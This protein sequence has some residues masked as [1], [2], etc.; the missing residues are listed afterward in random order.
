MPSS[1]KIVVSLIGL[2]LLEQQLPPIQASAGS[3]RAGAA[4]S[5]ITPPL[6]E[7]IVGNFRPT[8]AEH[9]HDELHARACAERVIK[10]QESPTEISIPLQAL[11]IGDVGIAAMAFEVFAEIGLEI[12][13]SSPFAKTFTIELANGSYDYLPTPRQHELGGYETWI[14][15]TNAV[16]VAASD[17]ITSGIL[18]LLAQLAPVSVQ[19][20]KSSA[21]DL[22]LHNGQIIT[23]DAAFST[24]QAIAVSG[25]K[26]I[27]IGQDADVLKHRG[28]GTTVI[29][30]NGKSV[31]PGLIDSHTH[32]V[33]ASMHEFNHP[34]PEMETVQDVLDYIAERTKVVEE[35]EW[36]GISQVFI[37]RLKE[38]RYPTKAE[39]DAVAPK[40]P[41]VFSTGPDSSVNSLALKLSGIDKNFQTENTGSKIE[42]DPV[43]GEP[44]G[45]LRNGGRY[46]KR[47]SRPAR[48]PTEAEREDRLRQ[49]FADYNAQGITGIC[50]RG[51]SKSGLE[52]YESLL[53]KDK[54]TVRI[55]ASYSA[56]SAENIA[57]VAKHPLRQENPMLR[58][59]GTKSMLDGGM[60][61]GSAFM[62]EPWGV[63][64]IYS[65][66][67][68]TYRGTL[69]I[70]HERLVSMVRAA[71][72]NNLQFTAHSVGDG[73]VH[74]LLAAYEEVNRTTPIAA[75]RPCLTHSNFMSREAIEQAARLGVCVDIQPVW[76]WLD[77]ETLEMQFS[78]DRLRWFQPL[79]SLFAAGVIAG[80]GSDHMQKIGPLRSVNPYDPWL[81]IW[82]TVNRVPRGLKVPLHSEEALTREQALRFYTANNAW[83][84]F[85]EKQTGSL[86]IGKLA[87]LIILDR[88]PLT[89]SLDELREMKVLSTYLGGK[90][91]FHRE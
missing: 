35:G 41:V 18:G 11:R 82:T 33:G 44:T 25:E 54:L 83:L 1:L 59:V 73:A 24:A 40:H 90:R 16:E 85:L 87:D 50:D 46:L 28:D 77:G 38:R 36:I 19:Q 81:G 14:G 34:I 5:R 12:K 79:K 45:I 29:D 43:T 17:K 52:L 64:S 91:V 80:G 56:G 51:A 57:A 84:M 39:L 23:V 88:D 65:I 30:L 26:I 76:L 68:P 20:Q 63:S 15:L 72:E 61:T 86:E 69:F 58:I 27:A 55:A 3:L 21:A 60:L 42:K 10:Q 8:P 67:D 4:V 62:R 66:D 13:E 53:I 6:G 7:P 31:L 74:A 22:I 32:S 9:I 2:L 49:L 78:E 37:T 47:T 70:P 89:C 48:Q 71:V 75:T